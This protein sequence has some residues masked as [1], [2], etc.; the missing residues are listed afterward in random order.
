MTI[1]MQSVA[2]GPKEKGPTT[3]KNLDPRREIP[4][5]YT[6]LDSVFCYL[7]QRDGINVSWACAQ[8][9]GLSDN[10]GGTSSRGGGWLAYN[11]AFR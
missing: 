8:H 6:E 10:T 7:R 4:C 1:L 2:E 5:R 11:T 9:V 3:R